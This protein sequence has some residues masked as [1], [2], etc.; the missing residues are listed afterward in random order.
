MK[1]LYYYQI[2]GVVYGEPRELMAE[3]AAELN[4]KCARMQLKARWLRQHEF[5]WIDGVKV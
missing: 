2:D 3:E 5:C 4:A 1:E